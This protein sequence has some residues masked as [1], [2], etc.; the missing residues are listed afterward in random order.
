MSLVSLLIL[1]IA[2]AGGIL[3]LY[4]PTQRSL[5]STLVKPD[6]PGSHLRNGLKGGR[7][8]RHFIL[9]LRLENEV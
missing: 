9:I 8:T 5:G 4:L 6:L 7:V 2:A 3:L 1:T